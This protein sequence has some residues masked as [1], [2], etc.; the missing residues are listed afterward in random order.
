VSEPREIP[1]ARA[2]ID[3]ERWSDALA[4]LVPHVATEPGDAQAW[5]LIAQS[6][7]G[8]GRSDAALQAAKTARTLTPESEWAHRL[9]SVAYMRRGL[10][11]EARRAAEES[12]RL[13]PDLWVTH[14]QRAEVDIQAN[15]I[16]HVTWDAA[17]RAVELAPQE[18]DAHTT[19]GRLA[20]ATGA[21]DMAT[22]AFREALR[23]DPQSATARNNLAVVHLRRKRLGSAVTHLVGA[24]R[25]DPTSELFANNLK[26]VLRS[27]AFLINMIG[28][29]GSAILLATTSD[30]VV[31]GSTSAPYTVGPTF[32]P[33]T[34]TLGPGNVVTL[35][36][37]PGEP[38]YGVV[39]V[40][41]DQVHIPVVGRPAALIIVACVVVA[42][43]IANV[44]VV[45]R[46]LGSSAWSILVA[47]ARRDEILAISLGL[48]GFVVGGCVVAAALGMPLARPAL[49]VT[50]LTALGSIVMMRINAP[51]RRR[52]RRRQWG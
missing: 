18:S 27:W 22:K 13:E 37:V 42:A 19:V 15:A 38:G 52:A 36:S 26:I 21:N 46:N 32:P 50:F 39:Q 28:A 31:S 8:L 23:L 47:A 20:L 35:S 16:T 29:V 43:L 4:I 17:R 24:L 7:L 9:C 1:R 6:H 41:V 12:M 25:A 14:R 3:A 49:V 48:S 44:I 10:F 30:R 51:K 45:R 11:A 40:P 5:C 2:L 34:Y 33:G